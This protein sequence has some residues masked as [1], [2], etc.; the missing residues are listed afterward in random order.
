MYSR[1]YWGLS[2]RLLSKTDS[3]DSL[4]TLFVNNMIYY[5]K[6]FKIQSSWSGRRIVYLMTNV[7]GKRKERSI[8]L[9]TCSIG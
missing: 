9:S 3:T 7:M 1:L 2:R 8:L 5:I 6:T 4:L